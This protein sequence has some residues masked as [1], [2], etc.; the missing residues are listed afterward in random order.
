M[1][2]YPLPFVR[3]RR[4]FTEGVLLALAGSQSSD[5]GDLLP[6]RVKHR[7]RLFWHIG[8]RLVNDPASA[9][10]QP[11]AIPVVLNQHGIGDTAIGSVLAILEETVICPVPGTVLESISAKVVVELCRDL[12]I[13]CVESQFDLR[14]LCQ[15]DEFVGGRHARVS[16][17][18]LAGTGFCLA[19]VRR[20][21]QGKQG[22]EFVWPG[23]VY[24]KLLEAW[25][26]LVDQ[27]IAGQFTK[28]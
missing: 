1:V 20:F 10:Y 15:G 7:S 3:Y 2:T 11:G 22:R 27:D 28:T 8:E 23:P 13:R 14:T 16:E 26:G 5:A 18:L 24:T 19:G 17:V 12:G 4:F 21:S 9:F 6:P 25:G